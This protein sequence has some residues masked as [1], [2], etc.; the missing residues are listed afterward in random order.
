VDEAGVDADGVETLTRG[1]V[2]EAFAAPA[3][4]DPAPAETV[5]AKPPEPIDEVAPDLK[6]EGAIWIPGYWE[7][8]VATEEYIWISGLWR[9]PPPAMRWVPPYWTEADGG[10]QRVPGF[11]ISSDVTEL[12][13]REAPPESLDVGPSTPAPGENYF[14]VPGSWSHYDTGYRWRTG[15]WS[16]YRDDWC[17]VP[18][19]WYWTPAGCIYSGGYWDRR[20]IVRGHLFAPVAFRSNVYLRP[21]WRYRPWC[22]LDTSRLFVHLWIG[23]RFNNY[24][25]GNY[26]GGYG[27]WGFTPW[28][29]WNYG[30]RRCYDPL[31]SWSSVHY[32]RHGIDYIGRCR[33]WHNHYARH[34]HD[35]PGRNWAEQRR[36][37]AD[38]RGGDRGRG[39]NVLARELREVAQNQRDDAPLRLARV[40]ENQRERVRTVSDEIRKLH[41]E[42]SKLERNARIARN[43]GEGSA[44][45]A[46]TAGASATADAGE[47]PGN[48]GRAGEGNRGRGP[49]RTAKVSLPK[50]SDEFRRTV[51]TTE[52]P[53]TLEPGSNAAG[54]GSTARAE[55]G[56]GNADRSGRGKGGGNQTASGGKGQGKQGPDKQGSANQGSGERGGDSAAETARSTQDRIRAARETASQR[57][58]VSK[59][60]GNK[61]GGS[62]GNDS[63]GSGAA[64]DLQDRIRAARETAE[65]SRGSGGAGRPMARESGG[66]KASGGNSG[67]G[68]SV[69]KGSQ[70]RI[71]RSEA[72]RVDRQPTPRL[73]APRAERRVETPR[74]ETRRPD[75]SPRI[76]RTQPPRIERSSPPRMERS[77]A[78]RIESPRGG[79]SSSRGG[80]SRGSSSPRPSMSRASGSSARASM[81]RPSGGSQSSASRGSSGSRNSRSSRGRD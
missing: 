24:Y 80:A 79:G 27:R 19:R 20:P 70:P 42:R 8:D 1:P 58:S 51:R 33:G 37:I 72:P 29:N 23:P 40:D 16:P 48:D 4:A 53:N 64:R 81:S 39:Q 77:S 50:A 3:A 34:E 61:G 13:Y 28:C 7:W 62:K 9:V 73:E 46:S 17:W 25:F 6:P 14:Y 78:P 41:T 76:E 68:N 47:R 18:A 74:I 49:G 21:G 5:K 69:G 52:S 59:G 75:A 45:D 71:E 67:G 30:F 32:R 44:T 54:A 12:E 36:L 38:G 26:Y 63:Q 2:H 65:G 60:S 22:V 31:W 15:Y 43:D 10:W 66:S 57:D 11:W 35:R 56:R 55:E